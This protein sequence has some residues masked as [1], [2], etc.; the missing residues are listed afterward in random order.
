[1]TKKVCSQ[2]GKEKDI[3]LFTKKSKSPDGHAPECKECHNIMCRR[4]YFKKL[5]VNREKSR[6]QYFKHKDE[7]KYVEGRKQY[8][9]TH[10]KQRLAY[11]KE[12]KKK[13][14]GKT[15]AIQKRYIAK[16]KDK[17]KR[18][19]K[20]YVERH[21]EKIAKWR[22]EY[23]LK[24]KKRISEYKKQYYAEHKKEIQEYKHQNY[25]DNIDH[26]K[27]KAKEH[28]INNREE[29]NRKRM[30]YNATHP[31]ARI[32]HNVRT[33]INAVLKGKSR[34]GRMTDLIGCT[35]DFY[36]SYIESLWT[37]GMNWANMGKGKGKWSV[38]HIKPL[39]WFNLEDKEEQKKAF[40]YTNTNPMWY[41]ENASKSNRYSGNYNK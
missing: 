9:K 35:A 33:R 24:N 18:W 15:L 2:C 17:K 36:K 31:Q 28:A 12:Y 23:Y 30:E 13:N 19:D 21:K 32:A 4:S 10:A 41:S 25:L 1:M 16:N 5:E 6:Q 8:R 20:N 14:P 7:E 39:S 38:D 29:N 34:G 37:E 40:H 26:Y 22:K 27:K 3:E 11:D